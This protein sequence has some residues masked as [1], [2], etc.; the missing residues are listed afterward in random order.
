MA[1]KPR[2][3][4][5]VLLCTLL[6]VSQ[7]F[8]KTDEPKA[9]KPRFET[10]RAATAP[11]IDGDLS[12]EAWQSAPEITGF[13]QHDPEDGKPATEKTVVK[14]VYDDNAIYFGARMDD[15]KPV[16]TLLG[17]RDT[18][19]QSDWLGI[20]IDSQLDGLS[21]AAFWV[22]P[23][24]VQVDMNLYNDI[25]NDWGWDAVWPSAAKIGASGWTAEVR[26]PYSQLRFPKKDVQTWG[27][28][29][30]RRIARNNERAWLV[31]TPKGQTGTVSR[32]AE[33]GGITGIQP[34][35]A[36]ELMPYGVAR[37]DLNSR[38]DQSN[39]FMSS[40]EHRIDAGLDV[41]YSLSSSL[42][43]TGTINPDFGQVEVDP[44]VVNLSQF[45]TFFPEKRPF[46]TEGANIF[47]FGNGPS[48]S[49]SNFN[50]RSP[51]IFYTRRIGRQPQGSVAAD[52]GDVP[53]ETTI[54]GAAKITGK[55]GKGWTVGVIDAITD[56]ESATFLR[57]GRQWKQQVEPMSNYLVGRLMKEYGKSSRIGFMFTGVNRRL[58]DELSALRSA[59]Y[60]A[61][62]D[63]YTLFKDKSWL[64]EWQGGG[65][66][67]EGS[68]EA[69]SIAQRS[70]ARYYQRPDADN[71]EFDPTR[72]TL[73]GWGG[74]AML[75]KQTGKWRPNIQIQTYSPGF[76]VNDVGFMNRTDIVNAHAMLFYLDETVGT[77]FRE[78]SFWVAKF[79]NWNHGGDMLANGQM[80]N[81]YL[82]FKNY[83]YTYG[84]GGFAGEVLD[85][86][87][88]RGGPLAKNAGH[89]WVGMGVGSDSRKKVFFEL[90]TELGQVDDGGGWH[91]TGLTMR[92]QPTTALKLSI[93]PSFIKEKTFAQ[94][95][96]NLPDPSAAETYGTAY[97]FATIDQRTIDLATRVDWTVSSRLSVQMY[98]QP[99]VA[100]GDYSDFKRLARP[101]SNEYV[102]A[103]E[104]F[105]PDFNFRSVRGSAVV[106]W[107]FRPGS[108]LY[109]V[110]NENRAGSEGIGDFRLRR[111]LSAIPSLPSQDVFLIK[112]SYWLPL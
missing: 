27:I 112:M 89:H 74:R 95:V 32:F 81:Y 36:L 19:L 105:N 26:I 90:T 94:H 45:E 71:V 62:V 43:L 59:A 31:N 65:S 67:I 99:F 82:E 12:D 53:G 73:S 80:G 83:W 47:K 79:N 20:Y 77:H 78:K 56:K 69:M 46:F 54:L 4:P 88:T 37:S 76:E 6:A 106:R 23:S 103:A 68:E 1:L 93:T 58:P 10:V 108:A 48:N 109:M 98:L 7:G 104:P 11:V 51:D 96:V 60:T 91:W 25:Y 30:L 9:P 38:F 97:T 92:Y 111:D 49:R 75:N 70:A 50:F 100:T 42:R 16:T 13:T 35:R 5:P 64:F 85:D 17:R 110:W 41:K 33:L 34:E 72:T 21:G 87:K 22:N 40:Y 66:R 101:R 61:G 107:E 24:N 2:S 18:D 86:R 63:G 52:Y 57:D 55:F 8:G 102:A 3:L 15:S 14:V 29:F 39:P 44:A 28:N 84:F